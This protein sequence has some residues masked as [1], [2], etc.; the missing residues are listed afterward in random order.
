AGRPPAGACG[1]V[2]DRR[3]RRLSCVGPEPRRLLRQRHGA[4]RRPRPRIQAAAGRGGRGGLGAN[5]AALAGLP[6]GDDQE[7]LMYAPTYYPGVGSPADAR[8]VTVGVSQEVDAIDFALQLVRTARVS[9]HVEN[10]DGSWTAQ[11]NVQLAPQA[12]G[13]RGNFGQ[14]YGGRIGWDGQFSIANVPPGQYILRARNQD[15]DAPLSTA[16]PLSVAS[17]GGDLTNVVVVL[18]TGG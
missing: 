6:P 10:P 7:Q 14:N 9:G 16:Q 1:T 11:G 2:A 17:G 3:S 18:Q 12:T 5:I 13:A 8:A 4:E 15:R